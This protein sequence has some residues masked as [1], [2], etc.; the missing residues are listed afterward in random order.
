MLPPLIMT[1]PSKINN[2]KSLSSSSTVAP[3][4]YNLLNNGLL[5]PVKEKGK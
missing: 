5:R 1:E 2:L 4:E 3:N